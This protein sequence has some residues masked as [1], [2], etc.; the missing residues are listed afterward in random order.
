MYDQLIANL[1][2]SLETLKS[3]QAK[4]NSQFSEKAEQIDSI[5]TIPH[6]GSIRRSIMWLKD[7]INELENARNMYEDLTK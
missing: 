1:Q 5:R 4:L 2:D 7:S 3:Q 6:N